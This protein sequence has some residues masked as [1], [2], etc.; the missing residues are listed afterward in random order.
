M[1]FFFLV[2]G[3]EAKRELDLGELRER[4]R[5]TIPA[6]RGDRRHGRSGPIYLAFNAGGPGA[7]GWGAA[8]S[9]DTA[10]ALGALALLTPRSA[11]RLRVFL[12]TLAVV[13]DLCALLVIAHRVHDARVGRR[14]GDRDR[15]VRRA[16]RAALCARVAAPALG[17]GRRR[18]VGGDVQVGHRPGHL[19]AR[20]R[21]GDER[22][23]ALARGP[24]ARDR[25]DAVVPRAADARAGALGP[26]QR[27]LGDLA[28]RAAPVRPASVD[29]LRDRAAVRAGQRRDPHHRRAARR[30][31]RLADHA[32]HPRRLRGRQAAR[33]RR[34][35]RGS[36]RARRCT[37][38]ERRSAGPL[39]VGR[40]RRAR[41]SASPSR[42]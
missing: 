6:L 1:T 13:D 21:P 31:R 28:Q 16:D 14:A 12:L 19:R 29:E 42:C 24:R 18:A 40:R 37:G 25:A 27:A 10:F 36:P 15:P 5:L 30:R 7:H 9:T 32:R 4:R 3:L 39:L 26:A 34:A 35:P 23:P 41:G 33:H 17:R 8:M 22:L 2:V 11:T 38:R 20:R